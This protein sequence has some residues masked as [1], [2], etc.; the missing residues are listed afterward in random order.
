MIRI[1]VAPA[2]R[3]RVTK[4]EASGPV[5]SGSKTAVVS[6]RAAS[7]EWAQLAA[8]QLTQTRAAIPADS[9]GC[10]TGPA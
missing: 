1:A 4:A 6:G 8:T 3:T 2:P 7:P 5:I 9:R 10:G